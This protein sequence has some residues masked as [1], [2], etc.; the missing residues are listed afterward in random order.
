[1]YDDSP[2]PVRRFPKVPLDRR[3]WAFFIDFA[4]A[5]LISGLGGIY[6]QWLIFLGAWFAL[7]VIV[8]ER[9]Q[10][11]SLGSWALDMK[12]ID[13]FRRIPDLTCLSKRE[14]IL[15]ILAMLAMYGLQIN[16]S[17]GIS[18]LL[19]LSPLMA[20]CGFAIADEEFNQAFHDRIAET[21]MIQTRRGFSLD[22]RLKQLLAEF[23]QNMQK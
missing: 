19:L 7:R 22:L 4:C 15:G 16:V 21:Y 10:G 8:V 6:F 13:R 23:R 14:G 20:S 12:I 9:N 3:F 17:N 1:M 11:Q 5:W 2:P 18:M